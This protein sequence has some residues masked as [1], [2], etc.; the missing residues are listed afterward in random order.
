[1][2][3]S[4]RPGEVNHDAPSLLRQTMG[5]RVQPGQWVLRKTVVAEKGQEDDLSGFTKSNT[6]VLPVFPNALPQNTRSLRTL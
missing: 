6:F 2:P 3:S 4:G 5:G 1:M